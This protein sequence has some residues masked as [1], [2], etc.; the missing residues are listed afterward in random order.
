MR[1]LL[2]AREFTTLPLV[3]DG[4]EDLTSSEVNALVESV[5]GKLKVHGKARLGGF[6][7]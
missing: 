3:F 5:Y 7:F 2:R 1:E 6:V 4:T